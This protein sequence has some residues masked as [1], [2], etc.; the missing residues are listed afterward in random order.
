MSRLFANL[1]ENSQLWWGGA[2]ICPPEADHLPRRSFSHFIIDE[3][4]DEAFFE[5]ISKLFWKSLG[6]TAEARS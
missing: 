5:E 1:L 6:V 2:N 3:V 4:S